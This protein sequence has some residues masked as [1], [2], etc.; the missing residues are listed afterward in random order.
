MFEHEGDE[1]TCRVERVDVTWHSLKNIAG[2]IIHCPTWENYKNILKELKY[3]IRD[4]GHRGINTK[5]LLNWCLYMVNGK[6]R[7]L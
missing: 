1:R 3:I 4:D 5:Y 7:K 2:G 6:L